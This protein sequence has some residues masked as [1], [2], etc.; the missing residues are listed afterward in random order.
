MKIFLLIGCLLAFSATHAQKKKTISVRGT[1]EILL[2]EADCIGRAK[3]KAVDMAKLNAL[4]SAFGKVIVQGTNIYIKN[5]GT[6][7]MAQTSTVMNTIANT[8]V[9]GEFVEEEVTRLEWVLRDKYTN[10]TDMQQELWL[11]CEVEG[12]AREVSAEKAAFKVATLN[13]PDQGCETAVFKNDERFYLSFKSPIAGYVSVFMKDFE[14][15]V[16][17][18]ILPYQRMEGDYESTIP[19]KADQQYIFFSQEAHKELFP[20]LASY[21]VD[22]IS[23]GTTEEQLFNRMYITF[24]TTPFVKPTLDAK[25]EYNYFKTTDFDS[26]QTWLNRNRARDQ[27][28]QME[29]ID[30]TIKR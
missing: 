1:S 19:V 22:P 24:S 5:T 20:S 13:C 11:M 21:V 2:E 30:V 3:Q 17:Y 18:R 8:M 25:A 7:E 14:E 29:I 23:L 15:D 27:S 6:G 4:E 9:N 12:K 28:F 26:F 16:V 10:S